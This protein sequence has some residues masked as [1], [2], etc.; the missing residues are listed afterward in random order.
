[1]FC[2]VFALSCPWL[3][4]AA[5]QPPPFEWVRT[6][7]SARG[8][9]CWAAAV[10]SQTNVYITGYF[11]GTTVF[12]TN[13]LSAPQSDLFVAKY[14]RAGNCL[15]ARA[16]GSPTD[17]VGRALTVDHNGNLI[18]TGG[19][20][21]SLFS[22]T[23]LLV[24]GGASANYNVFVAKYDTSGTLL[25]SRQGGGASDDSGGGVGTD[26]ANNYYVTGYFIDQAT[27]GTNVISRPATK[28]AFIAKY[29][30][31]GGL[32]WVRQTQG[33]DAD[34]GAVIAVDTVG[35][36]YLTG[37]FSGTNILFGGIRV[38]NH[39]TKSDIFVVKYDAGG[40]P[41]WA[42]G[43]GGSGAGAYI[44]AAPAGEDAGQAIAVDPS[45]N[46]FVAGV[47]SAT[48]QF[49]SN[50]LTASLTNGN[51]QNVF[52]AKYDA[53]GNV[54]WA[55]QS[56]NA[57]FPT[58]VGG[59]ATDSSGDAYLA[60]F[61]SDQITFGNSNHV[62]LGNRDAFIA[63]WN[64]VGNFVW[65]RS[66]GSTNRDSSL[67]VAV[68]DPNTLFVAGEFSGPA[69][70]GTL[71]ATNAGSR[72][73]FVARL[74]WNVPVLRITR[75]NQQVK[76]SW[77]VSATNNVLESASTLSAAWSPLAAPTLVTNNENMVLVSPTNSARYYRLNFTP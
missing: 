4:R 64:G 13:V 41:I 67:G 5:T 11:H 20:I 22:D 56:T 54:I 42:A 32:L 63:K 69:T 31:T 47:F 6:A 71:T 52:L 38:T 57:L 50:T 7:G 9:L 77:A 46:V 27:F 2:F 51:A 33:S 58:G 12:G 70:F 34:D 15:W 45:G 40:K 74:G 65:S 29:S 66:F 43:A 14:D 10:D 59:L 68:Q 39:N 36:S 75:T 19:F 1:M 49:G 3:T 17:G 48:A 25:W 37:S 44:P 55:R 26:A 23:N 60:G 18:V 62:S 28:G 8:E 16:G 76:L 30:S 53:N 24:G 72:D 61:F 35:N 73:M 21:N